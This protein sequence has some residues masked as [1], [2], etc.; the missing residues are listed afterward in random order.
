MGHRFAVAVL[1]ALESASA[2]RAAEPAPTVLAATAPAPPRL[3]AGQRKYQSIFPVNI[4]DEVLEPLK[5][6]EGV[7]DADVELYVGDVAKQPIR[8][9]GVQTNR[10]A[11]KGNAMLN[12]FRYD[13]GSYEGTGMW[14][15]D[16]FTNRYTGVWIDSDTHLVRHDIGYY[17][18]ESRTFRWEADTMQPDGVTT[19]MRIVQQFKGDIRT[20]QIDLM[21]AKTG[22]FNKLIYMTFTRRAAF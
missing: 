22:A 6:E 11:S 15:W 20:F 17:D 13:D 4:P 19:R 7:W 12:A 3:S 5:A 9:T 10:L 1:I 2:G 8:K 14:G 16:A 21:D 18:P